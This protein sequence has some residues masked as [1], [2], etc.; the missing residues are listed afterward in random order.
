[1]SRISSSARRVFD[2]DIDYSEWSLVS[3]SL[4]QKIA[5]FAIKGSIMIG[6][7]LLSQREYQNMS[8][9]WLK[10]R[11][12]QSNCL[13]RTN[14][15]ILDEHMCLKRAIMI[16]NCCTEES[17]SHILR[18]HPA[19]RL[20]TMIREFCLVFNFEFINHITCYSHVH[21]IG[22]IIFRGLFY[23]VYIMNCTIWMSFINR[24][25]VLT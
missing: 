8:F 17:V 23:V 19:I 1:M 10:S 5:N 24:L 14:L 13:K 4:N 9:E 22:H 18:L 15:Y 12:M 3:V 11:L 21:K 7:W 6:Q 16:W 20:Q 25:E 2:S